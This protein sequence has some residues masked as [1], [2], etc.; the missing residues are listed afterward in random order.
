MFPDGAVLEHLPYFSYCV[1]PF[2][3]PFQDTPVQ[4]RTELCQR[5]AEQKHHQANV[6][7]GNYSRESLVI[8]YKL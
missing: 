3:A 8:K 2:S 7:N 4:K 5:P 6:Q 1:A